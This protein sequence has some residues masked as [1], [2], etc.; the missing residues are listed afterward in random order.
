M[1]KHN[2]GN[3]QMNEIY[4]KKACGGN[5]A[6]G[7]LQPTTTSSPKIIASYYQITLIRVLFAFMAHVSSTSFSSCQRLLL[8]EVPM[9]I[10]LH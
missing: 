5:S 7:Y 6:L 2:S 1:M 8:L 4:I 3:K 10:Q 9:Q